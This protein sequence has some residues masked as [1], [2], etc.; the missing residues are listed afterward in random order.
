MFGRMKKMFRDEE[1]GAILG[2]AG[3]GSIAG[4]FSA[5]LGAIVGCCGGTICGCIGP[6]APLSWCCGSIPIGCLGGTG[7]G[8]VI[9][10]VINA[11]VGCCSGGLIGTWID[12]IL[13]CCTAIPSTITGCCNFIPSLLGGLMGGK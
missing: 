12:Y 3:L 9:G 1:A 4:V 10:G 7:C 11:C 13:A 5:I 2:A 8:G 6:F